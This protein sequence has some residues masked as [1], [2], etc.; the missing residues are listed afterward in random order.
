MGKA[1]DLTGQR[2]G[3]LTVLSRAGSKN[4]HTTWLCQCDCGNQIV[5]SC[6][7]LVQNRSKSCG[8]FKREKLINYSRSEEK[9]EIS[10]EQMT[11]HGGRYTRLY[12]IWRAM[13]N[14]CS[15]PHSKDFK[16]YGERGISV[17]ADWQNNYKKFEGWALT[18]GYSEVLTIDRIDVDGNYEPSNCRWA[19]RAEQN[20]NKR[21]TSHGTKSKAGYAS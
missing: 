14:R 20:K 7:H 1:L 13:K 5:A 11:V 2:Y 8:C 6:C 4:G 21:R 12:R 19:T 10:R 18:H 16:Y 15:N 3:R 17:C 9:K